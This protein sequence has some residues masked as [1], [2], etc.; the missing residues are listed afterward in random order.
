MQKTKKPSKRRRRRRQENLRIIPLGGLGEVGKNMTLF[1]YGR[2]I[3]IVDIGLKFPEESTPGVDFIIPN[4]S[5]LKGKE[6]N[7]VGVV[8]T[9]GHYDHIGAIPYLIDKIGLGAPMFASSLTQGIILRRQDEFPEKGKLNIKSVKNGERIKLGPFEIEFVS[10]NHNIPDNFAFLIKTP[11]GYILHTSD[12]KFDKSPINDRPTNIKRLKSIGDKGILLLMADST[13]AEE[14][15][16]SLS[17]KE[18]MANLEKIFQ[19]TKGRIIV[20]TFSSL[21]NRVQQVITLSEKY[22][23]KVAIEGRSMRTN[24]EMA[25]GLK[26]IKMKRGTQIEVK[27][28]GRYSDNNLTIVCTGAQ[29]EAEAALMRIANREHRFI[30]FKA[31]DTVIFSSS[32]VPGNERTV[33]NL[34]D[35]ILR[36]RAD[37]YHYKMMDVHAG[38]HAKKEEL[39]EMMKL[40]RPKFFIPVHGQYSMLIEHAKL[41][42]EKARLPAKS[43]LVVEN[44]DIVSLSRNKMLLLKDKVP[45]NYVMV[46]GSGVGDIGEI[47]L[48]DRKILVDDG[49]FVIIAVVDRQ[50]GRVRTSPDIIS[51]GFIYL[52]ESQSLLA[53]VRKKV[54]HIINNASTEKIV[55]WTNLK[56]ELK[57]KIGGFLYSKTKRRPMVVPVIIEI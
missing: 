24:V 55:N 51:R 18:I 50:T 3:L 30:K 9:H 27:N 53:Q 41:A 28:I 15:G 10:I 48:R 45:A 21:I 20:S 2:K 33:Q 12:F 8:F 7:I 29:G 38:G 19:V 42:E 39:L 40:M 32:I 57:N 44:G 25:K 56:E 26:Y 22:H 23:R 17:E 43:I 31:N 11:I 36:Q 35:N 52:R 46:D 4:V 16:H 37:V 47:V 6:K 49:I 14:E 5:Y 54:V 34:K 13:G 1:E